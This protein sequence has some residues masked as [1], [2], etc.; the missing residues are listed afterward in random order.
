M[1]CWSLATWHVWWQ[2]RHPLVLLPHVEN[3]LN[4]VDAYFDVLVFLFATVAT[5]AAAVAAVAAVAAAFAFVFVLVVVVVVV[6]V[7]VF[8]CCCCCGSSFYHSFFFLLLLF[9]LFF[10]FFFFLSS[11]SSSSLQSVSVPSTDKVANKR[12]LML[13]HF[14]LVLLVLLY[15]RGEKK[16]LRSASHGAVDKAQLDTGGFLQ[17]TPPNFNSPLR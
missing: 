6:V 8:F 4:D 9:L 13:F 15:V 2:V 12:L 17:R 3:S 11:S 7:L 5:V 14:A 1:F 10:F 16:I